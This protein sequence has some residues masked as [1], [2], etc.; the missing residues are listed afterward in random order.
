MSATR[1][2]A[3]ILGFAD[4]REQAQRLAQ[5]A[6]LAYAEV[7]VRSFPDGESL[8]QLPEQLPAHVIFC[9]PLIDANR[10]LVELELAMA[11]A[12]QLGASRLTLV[13]PYLCYMR[14][15]RA[16]HPGEA[17][18]QRIIG[19]FLARR[20][21][22]LVTVDPHLH[23]TRRLAEAVPVE[24]AVVVTAAPLMSAWLDEHATDP[25]LVGPDEESGQWVSE[26]ARPGSLEYCVARKQRHG[27]HDV[28]IAVPDRNFGGR[29]V[30]LADDVI[31]TG[32]T[33]AE[34]ARELLARGAR[35]VAVLASHALC[36]EGSIDRLQ[37]AGVGEIVSSDS[38]PHPSNRLQLHGLLAEALAS[39]PG[40][41]TR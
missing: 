5:A 9:R 40:A 24:S 7:R 8:V 23:R 33:L 34:A 13:A 36:A 16:F 22:A 28:T 32:T 12:G 30:V 20:L 1:E 41:E 17:V 27:D 38:I 14:Q 21:D 10:R 15:D 4:Y 39:L 37:A 3:V 26:I 19:E 11:T 2:Q 29:D 25:L 35:S 18:S 6:G 31:S